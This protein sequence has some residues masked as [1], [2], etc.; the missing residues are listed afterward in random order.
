MPAA[1]LCPKAAVQTLR[2]SGAGQTQTSL[3]ARSLARP[4]LLP[5]KP[6]AWRHLIIYAN[7]H[8]LVSL[9]HTCVYMCAW[10]QIHTYKEACG[11]IRVFYFSHFRWSICVTWEQFISNASVPEE[12]GSTV[13][14]YSFY[15]AF[16]AWPHL[17]EVLEFACDFLPSIP[18]IPSQRN[19]QRVGQDDRQEA[20]CWTGSFHSC[21]LYFFFK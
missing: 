19:T 14:L 6:L 10:I 1:R 17:Q 8:C 16:P 18:Q 5:G 4:V 7:E 2:G 13:A 3:L 9:A 20:D 21:P 15:C 12:E 11:C